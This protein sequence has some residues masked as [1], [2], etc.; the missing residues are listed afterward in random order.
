MASKRYLDQT[1]KLPQL[2]VVVAIDSNRSLLKA[3]AA[4]SLS[5]PALTK[6]LHDLE[7]KLQLKLFDR[8]ARGVRP[9]EAGAVVIRAARRILAEVHRLD[10][11]LEML[12]VEGGGTV[13]V[14]AL[15]VAAAGILPGVLARLKAAYPQLGVRV[16]QGRTDDLLPL[17]ASGEI[18]LVLGRL[19]EATDT[20]RFAREPLWL[21]PFS[22]L[23]HAGHRIFAQGAPT[24]EDLKAC[25]F[26]LPTMTQRL[27]QEIETIRAALGLDGTAT[28]R[29]TSYE[30]IR[31]MLHGTD[32]LTIVPRLVMA[33]DLRRGTLR[34]VPVPV[35]GPRRTAGLILSRSG[36]ERPT[37][38]I[39]RGF[40]NAHLEEGGRQGI[41]VSLT[42]PAAAAT[43][44]D[45]DGANG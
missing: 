27:G 5:Q 24:V 30:F 39:F 26:V 34:V 32:M 40:L 23:A 37:Q 20:D 45:G 42:P 9:T 43:A 28:L 36:A 19:Y 12:E 38:R 3:S 31:E 44:A 18:D 29:S 33:G 6:T 13:A 1:L 10:D 11:D 22:I 2:R 15:P 14:G 35:A 17:L 7:E 41:I 4:L 8:H 21:E 25:E 16:H